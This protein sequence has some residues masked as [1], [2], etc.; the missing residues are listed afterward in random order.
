MVLVSLIWSWFCL[1]VF[2]KG[3]FGITRGI[4]GELVNECCKQLGIKN[5]DSKLVQQ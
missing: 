5:I 1:Y 4:L 3:F 2:I